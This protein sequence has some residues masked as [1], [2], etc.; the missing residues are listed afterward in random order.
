M[1]GFVGIAML[2]SAGT[3]LYVATVHVLADI[4]Q[5]AHQAS[6][7]RLPVASTEVGIKGPPNQALKGLTLTELIIL[8]IGCLMPL[9]LT[10]GHHHWYWMYRFLFFLYY[11]SLFSFFL[12]SNLWRCLWSYEILLRCKFCGPK[13]ELNVYWV[14]SVVFRTKPNHKLWHKCLEN[15]EYKLKWKQI[16]NTAIFIV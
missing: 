4:T 15:S 10:V 3:F 12:Y 13:C 16:Y 2:F 1:G 11:F 14:K 9:V 5:N 8:V 6:Y 7:T